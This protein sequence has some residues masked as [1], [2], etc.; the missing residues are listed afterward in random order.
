ME[1]TF[2]TAAGG[3]LSASTQVRRSMRAR[4]P[5]SAACV[6]EKSRSCADFQLLYH[7]LG[8]DIALLDVDVMDDV[9]AGNAGDEG[10][11]CKAG[12]NNE[13]LFHLLTRR[14]PPE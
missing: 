1:N 8:H 9:P 11:T 6:A 14:V 13:K 7:V 12:D 5:S 10:Q 4:R 3:A 2:S